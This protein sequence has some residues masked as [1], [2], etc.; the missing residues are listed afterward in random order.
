MS[1]LEERARAYP[2][3]AITIEATLEPG[4]NYSRYYAWYLS[5][6]LKIYGLLTVP[7]GDKPA[8]GWP[9]IVFNH[10]YIAPE[11]YKT[12][13]RYVGYMDQL[14]RHGYIVY[15]I[16]YRGNDRSQGE[17]TGAYGSPGYTTDVLNA[18]SSLK[19]FPQT[20]PER[21][22]MWGHSMGG[23]L[24]LRAM[25][26][27]K[28]IKAGVINRWWALIQICLASPP[29]RVDLYP[30]PIITSAGATSGIAY[31]AHLNR[32]LPSGWKYRQIHICRIYRD[33][34]RYIMTS[35]IQT[36]RS[37]FRKTCTRR[38]W[39]WEK[40]PNIMNIQGMTITSPIISTWR[41][42]GLLNFSIC[43]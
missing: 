37:N 28:E 36:C 16:D 31:T 34:C 33:R 32:T 2:G 22:G 10:G 20:N 11:V 18:V 15:K 5:D 38:Y 30:T 1:I 23:F 21:I 14:A 35:E 8:N 17:A 42:R 26:I 4:A 12:T 29:A 3:S 13:E 40:L 25:V 24:T 39:Q 41:C 27:S 6:G 19:Q 9:A 43:T 7:F